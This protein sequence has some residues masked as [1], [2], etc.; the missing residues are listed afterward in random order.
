MNPPD[1]YPEIR[2]TIILQNP[3]Y[4]VLAARRS[5]SGQGAGSPAGWC[6]VKNGWCKI[7]LVFEIVGV[8]AGWCHVFSCFPNCS[9]M[10]TLLL[11]SIRNTHCFFSS[12]LFSRVSIWFH[13]DV[14]NGNPFSGPF[15]YYL[16]R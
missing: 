5:S 3:K 15:N 16:L 12:S 14:G 8:R 4:R 10:V 9:S 7:C 13:D 6:N 1:F 2:Q 11:D